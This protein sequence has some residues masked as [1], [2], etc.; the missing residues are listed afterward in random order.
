MANQK[1]YLTEIYQDLSNWLDEMTELQKPKIIELVK[2]AKLY[3]K[4]AE[5]MSEEKVNQFTENLKYDLHD[6]YLQ[7]QSEAKNSTYLG[8]LNETLWSTLA[9]LTDKSQVEWAEL[10]DDFEHEGLYK[11]GDVIGFG[12]LV[13]Q[14]CDDKQHIVHFSKVT[15][16]VKCGG[17]SFTRLPLAP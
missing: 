5:D 10:M 3:A 11:V 6:F 16:C 13:C 17:N 15:E 4:A 1:D 14:Q 2:Q 9:Q 12:E 7:N 8:L